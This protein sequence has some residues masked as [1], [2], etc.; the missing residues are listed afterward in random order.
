MLKH[1]NAN[2]TLRIMNKT[3]ISVA[4]NKVLLQKLN[5]ICETEKRSRSNYIEIAIEEKI[6]KK[7]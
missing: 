4:I 5:K 2:K 3:T 1:N 6:T 7:I